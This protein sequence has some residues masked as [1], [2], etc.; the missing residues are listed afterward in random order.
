MMV[1]YLLAV[2]LKLIDAVWK[3]VGNSDEEKLGT[4]FISLV[5]LTFFLY[6]FTYA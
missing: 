1:S 2:I 4:L 3:L 6:H 5:K